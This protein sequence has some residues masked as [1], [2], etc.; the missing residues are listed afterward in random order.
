MIQDTIKKRFQEIS[1]TG[2]YKL[3]TLYYKFLSM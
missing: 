3:F 2:N 1:E